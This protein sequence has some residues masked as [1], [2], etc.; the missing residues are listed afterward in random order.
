MTDERSTATVRALNVVTVRVAVPLV[1]AQFST[2]CITSKK[3][4]FDHVIVSLTTEFAIEVRNFLLRPFEDDVY[5]TLKVELIKHTVAS[6]QRKLQQ[7]ISG[8]ELWNG[9]PTQILSHAAAPRGQTRYICTPSSSSVLWSAFTQHRSGWFSPSRKR[10][11]TAASGRLG[12]Q[13]H[14]GCHAHYSAITH[15]WQDTSKVKQ[16]SE[17]VTHLRE[18]VA[19]LTT[20]SRLRESSMSPPRRH[21]SPAAQQ[22]DSS[23]Y[24]EAVWKCK[25]PCSWGNGPVWTLVVTGATGPFTVAYVS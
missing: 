15:D 8:E 6:E 12:R 14:G 23:R 21:H 7:L 10:Q 11:W 19:F 5:N 22:H 9:E 16:L 17:E 25:E 18:L 13:C 20:W 24:G 2:C 4:R 3:T 1:E